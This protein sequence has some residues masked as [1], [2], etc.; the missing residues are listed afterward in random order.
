MGCDRCL[1]LSGRCS[2]HSVRPK[3]GDRRLAPLRAAGHGSDPDR[4]QLSPTL[5]AVSAPRIPSVS[6]GATSVA[7]SVPQGKPRPWLK[8]TSKNPSYS[9]SRRR[10]GSSGFGFRFSPWSECLLTLATTDRKAL[11]PGL[12]RD[13]D[14]DGGPR[15]SF[16]PQ[17]T[18]KSRLK[19]LPPGSRRGSTQEYPQN[20][21]QGR[22][23]EDLTQSCCAS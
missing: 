23:S 16:L 10:P 19:S 12:R 8:E 17:P 15:G 2:S 13:D 1:H 20:A 11:D 18:A 22:F 21:A 5:P 9:S 6:V 7:T 4:R 3:N 14:G